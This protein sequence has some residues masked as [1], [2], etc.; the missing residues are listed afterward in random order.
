VIDIVLRW[1]ASHHQWSTRTKF[2]SIFLWSASDFI[3]RYG[4]VGNTLR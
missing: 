2:S 3:T 1:N 4:F